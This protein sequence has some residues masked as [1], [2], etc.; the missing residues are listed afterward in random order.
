MGKAGEIVD[1]VSHAVV[2]ESNHEIHLT[3]RAYE[4]NGR[5]LRGM[6]FRFRLED[7]PAYLPGCRLLHKDISNVL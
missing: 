5:V 7:L 4:D 6:V 2:D 3:V 1:V